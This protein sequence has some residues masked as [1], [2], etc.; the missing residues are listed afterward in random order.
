MKTLPIENM[1]RLVILDDRQF[2][3][4]KEKGYVI[5]AWIQKN[6]DSSLHVYEA[7]GN[8]VCSLKALFY[9]EAYMVKYVNGNKFDYRLSNIRSYSKIDEDVKHGSVETKM[10]KLKLIRKEITKYLDHGKRYDA[11]LDTVDERLTNEL[12]EKLGLHKFIE[13]YHRV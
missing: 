4:I 2:F 13:M 1:N 10:K 3:T 11:H 12:M 9:P 5:R 6:H 8:Y 7:G